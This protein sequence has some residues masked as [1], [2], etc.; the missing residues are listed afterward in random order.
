MTYGTVNADVIG[1]SVA[2]S[3]L[4][5]GNASIMKNRIINGAMIVAQYGT[6][7]SVGTNSNGYSCDRFRCDSPVGAGITSAQNTSIVPT[8][9]AYS[10][11]YT[12]GTATTGANDNSEIVQFI[13]G[14]NIADLGWGTANAKTVTLSFWARSSLTGSFG[15][16]LENGTGLAQYVTTYSLPIANT[17]TFITLNIPA[18]TIGTWQ[19]NNARGIGIRWDMGVGT[20]ASTASTNAWNTVGSGALGVNGTVKLTQNTG[21]TFYITGVQLEVGSSATGFEYRQYGQE[22]ALCQRYYTQF[23]ST[24]TGT[25]STWTSILTFKATMRT[26]PT[27]VAGAGFV[28]QTIDSNSVTGYQTT[29][30]SSQLVTATAEL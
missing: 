8:G 5:A 20:S 24:V 27:I 29:A 6:S 23:T 13:E 17:W 1:T 12:A 21:A 16:I 2:G 7:T 28:S 4:G 14:Y 22:L 11:S 26:T 25:A 9:F 30:S 15:L 3:N 18:P 19:I 10:L